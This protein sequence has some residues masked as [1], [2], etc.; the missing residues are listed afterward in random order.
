MS[1]LR[2]AAKQVQLRKQRPPLEKKVLAIEY[3]LQVLQVAFTALCST[4]VRLGSEIAALTAQAAAARKPR[5][6]S[7]RSSR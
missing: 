5:R 4:N 7:K 1:E 3:Q 6:K 2:R